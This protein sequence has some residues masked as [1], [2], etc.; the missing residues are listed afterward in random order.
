MVHVVGA[1]PSRPWASP[2][3]RVNVTLKV[4]D[5]G[6]RP[7]S[8]AAV[9]VVLEGEEGESS[10][11][12]WEGHIDTEVI[13]ASVTVEVPQSPDGGEAVDPEV[14][15]RFALVVR[16]TDGSEL[17]RVPSAVAVRKRVLIRPRVVIASPD[18]TKVGDALLPGEK[19]VKTMDSADLTVMELTSGCRIYAKGDLVAGVDQDHPMDDIFWDKALDADLRLY[20]DL[21]EGLEKGAMATRAEAITMQVLVVSMG[22]GEGSASG[23]VK[24]TRELAKTFDPDRRTRGVSPRSGPLAPL[25]SWLADPLA[26]PD[27]GRKIVHDLRQRLDTT[28]GSLDREEATKVASAA[29][30][31]AFDHLD[32]LAEL[33]SRAWEAD[34]MD[35]KALRGATALVAAAGVA[36]VELQRLRATVD[37]WITPSQAQEGV[38][39]ALQSMSA[40]LASLLELEVRHRVRRAAC[41]VNTRQRAAQAAVVRDLEVEIPDRPG[42]SGDAA[43]LEVLLSNHSRT[44]LELRLNIALPTGAWAVLE[45]QG[46]GTRLV[47]VGAVKV[48]ARTQETLSLVL[49]VPTTVKLDTY[50]L[51]VEVVPQPRDVVP[52]QGGE[53]E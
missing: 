25:A 21:K 24:D 23:L 34:R 38:K 5:S 42:H 47:S 12:T 1:V 20:S 41:E 16:G 50:V 27:K 22:S 35:G 17:L 9:Q 10:Y 36:Q 14:S 3:E 51:P 40:Q 44:D 7:G 33:L 37:P 4:M 30:K 49:Y 19:V 8:D 28:S 29:A 6:S 32:R 48:T 26:T 11:T 13:E 2:G 45:P 43:D 53:R 39:A 52:E 18:P 31:A 15:N 46:R